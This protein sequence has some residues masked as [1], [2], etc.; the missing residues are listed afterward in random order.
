MDNRTQPGPGRGRDPRAARSNRRSPSS[1]R[2]RLLA[3]KPRKLAA[4]VPMRTEPPQARR[5]T[6][7]PARP[8]VPRPSL[9]ASRPARP[10]TPPP[11]EPKA[12]PATEPTIGPDAPPE[13]PQPPWLLRMLVVLDGVQFFWLFGLRPHRHY[14]SGLSHRPELAPVLLSLLGGV[15][16][17]FVWNRCRWAGWIVLLVNLLEVSLLR[18]YSCLTLLYAAWALTE[19]AV[20]RAW[21]GART[22]VAPRPGAGRALWHSPAGEEGGIATPKEERM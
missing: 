18:P 13:A 11:T 3:L 21:R 8:T 10:K 22:P 17:I 4:S 14:L 5:P 19:P 20:V 16:L 15:A 7:R 12:R 1:R 9:P 2:E 6:S